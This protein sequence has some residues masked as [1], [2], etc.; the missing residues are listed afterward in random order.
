MQGATSVDNGLIPLILLTGFTYF[1]EKLNI[2]C[3]SWILIGWVDKRDN[4]IGSD[5]SAGTAKNP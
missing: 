5:Q 2:N 4:S 3:E 1:A